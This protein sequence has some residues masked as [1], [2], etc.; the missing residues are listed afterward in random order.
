L[1]DTISCFAL[2]FQ[3][4]RR[5]ESRLST[6][7]VGA[8]I[9]PVGLILVA[10][11]DFWPPPS[12]GLSC[13]AREGGMFSAAASAAIHFFQSSGA[14]PRPSGAKA[15]PRPYERLT[16][17]TNLPPRSSRLEYHASL[18]RHGVTAGSERSG[19]DSQMTEDRQECALAGSQPKNSTIPVSRLYMAPVILIVPFASSPASTALSFRMSVKVSRHSYEQQRPRMHSSS[20]NAHHYMWWLPPRAGSWPAAQ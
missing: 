20:P 1:R 6:F 2:R 15:A 16:R 13:P 8:R 11:S 3:M 7:V 19:R 10:R 4:P 18:P 5:S 12:G 17:R 14:K 9:Q